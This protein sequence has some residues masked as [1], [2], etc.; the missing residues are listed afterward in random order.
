MARPVS[1]EGPGKTVGRHGG[2]MR[3]LVRQMVLVLS[4][5]SPGSFAVA[6]ERPS[7]VPGPPVHRHRG[8]VHCNLPDYRYMPCMYPPHML[9]PTCAHSLDSRVRTASGRRISRMVSSTLGSK[10]VHLGASSRQ[11]R[12]PGRG[13]WGTVQWWLGGL[14]LA[15]VQH[16]QQAGHHAAAG[17]EQFRRG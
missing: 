2:V 3:W 5:G 7:S 8:L 9:L 1:R 17:G 14:V 16:Q 12:A 10:C 4:R 11:G 15:C 13:R 6:C